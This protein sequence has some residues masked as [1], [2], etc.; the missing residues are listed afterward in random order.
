MKDYINHKFFISDKNE[1]EIKN[2]IKFNETFDLGDLYKLNEEYYLL[3][4]KNIIKIFPKIIYEYKFDFDLNFNFNYM[5]YFLLKENVLLVICFEY[6]LFLK[7][8][9]S[10][11]KI[12]FLNK[13]NNNI[14]FC[15]TIVEFNNY[16]VI[17]LFKKDQDNHHIVENYLIIFQKNNNNKNIH[18]TI[19]YQLK[20]NI[21][22]NI[23]LI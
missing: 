10:E 14:G 6:Y 21:R 5:K 19:Y 20:I 8:N 23:L 22:T 17:H 11:K 1:K 2:L 15:R 4:Y 18:N 12:H 3:R 7:I 9:F 13:I 16:I